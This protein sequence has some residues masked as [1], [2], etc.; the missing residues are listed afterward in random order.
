M[1]SVPVEGILREVVGKG[2][3]L[4]T[5]VGLTKALYCQVPM[6]G[7]K[8][9]KKLT[10]AV[11]LAKTVLVTAPLGV[12]PPLLLRKMP[13]L[14]LA[15]VELRTMKSIVLLLLVVLI[16]KAAFPVKPLTTVLSITIW[17]KLWLPLVET[18]QAAAP[19]LPIMSDC[20]I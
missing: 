5:G 11:L 19:A 17:L 20:W 6:V 8:P 4:L 16:P 7:G 15:R 12:R 9:A 18:A 14:L 10:S 2:V 3:G 13:N 1:N